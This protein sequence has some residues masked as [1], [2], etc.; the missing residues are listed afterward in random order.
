MPH[1][2]RNDS[3]DYFGLRLAIADKRIPENVGRRFLEID[4]AF[5]VDDA[6]NSILTPLINSIFS[7][8]ED[9][10]EESKFDQ[11]FWRILQDYIT[12]KKSREDVAADL[13]KLGT[14]MRAALLTPH[15]HRVVH[16]KTQPKSSR[17]P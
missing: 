14:D 16:Q 9:T 13:S 8:P 11:R 3:L 2:T 7:V 1:R 15:Q 10:R 4:R 17:Q 12:E 5:D 6:Q